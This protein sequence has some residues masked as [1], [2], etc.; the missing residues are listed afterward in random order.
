M[1]VLSEHVTNMKKEDLTDHLQQLQNFFMEALDFRA[2]FAKVLIV[3]IIGMTDF[4]SLIY[5]K[6]T[7]FS[8]V[9]L[10]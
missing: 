10:V 8:T 4:F 7:S 9:Y 6:R 3:F 1:S 2:K 5:V